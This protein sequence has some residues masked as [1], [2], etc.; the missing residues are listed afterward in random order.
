VFEELLAWGTCLYTLL[1][2][3]SNPNPNPIFLPSCPGPPVE[4]PAECGGHGSA[5]GPGPGPP[6]AAAE[7]RPAAAHLPAG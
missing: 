3:F 1:C 5:G 4:G 2:I 6:A 7:Q